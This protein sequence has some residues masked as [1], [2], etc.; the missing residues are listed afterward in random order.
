MS[1]Y[2]DALSRADEVFGSKERAKDWLEKMSAELGSAPKELLKTKEGYDR[3]LRHLHSVDL[4]LNFD[5]GASPFIWAW[6]PIKGIANV[7]YWQ[8]SAVCWP[9]H[10]RPLPGVE[11]PLDAGLAAMRSGAAAPDVLLYRLLLTQLGHTAEALYRSGL[12]QKSQLIWFF[13]ALLA[14]KPQ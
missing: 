6:S 9:A 2:S 7:R 3:V 10:E 5:W 14:Q 11:L 13:F 1:Y 4:A 8:I 12:R